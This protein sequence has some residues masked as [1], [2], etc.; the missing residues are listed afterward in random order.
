ME[1]EPATARTI[2]I[3]DPEN[4]ELVPAKDLVPAY[5][6]LTIPVQT[7]NRESR[8]YA[9]IRLINGLEATIVSDNLLDRS[10]GCIDVATGKFNDPED[11]AGTA[12]YCEHLLF[13]GSKKY[14]EENEFHEYIALNNGYFNAATGNSNTEFHFEVASDAL[15]GA[16]ERFSAFFYCPRFHKD[17]ALREIKSI[18]S[19]YSG[20][21]QDDIRRL[22]YMEF[23]L[24]HS[25][26]PLRKFGTGSEDT[27]I[28]KRSSSN[29]STRSANSTTGTLS[30]TEN[31]HISRE[32]T[33]IPSKTDPQAV[34]EEAK[35]V[36]A[37]KARE[38]L[39]KWWKRE[40]CAERMKLAIVGK[41]PLYEIIDMVVRL[42][43]P[44]K[45][46]GQYPAVVAFP[47]QPYGKEELGKIVYVKTIEKMYEIIITFPIPWQI[48]QW[49]EKPVY[50][51]AHLL[52][53]EGPHSL[54]A[55]LKN[56]GWLLRLL[57]GHAIYGHG[58]SLLKL[59]LELTKEGL[60]NY[61]EVI[62]T[63]FKFIN[64]LR[65]SQIPS[66]MHQERYWIEWLSFQHDREPQALPLVRNIVDSMKYPTRRDLLLNGPLLPWEWKPWEENPVKDMLENLDV[67]NCY[68]IV[69][70][71][72]HDHT[73][74]A[75]TWHKERWFGAEYVQK[76]FDAKFISKA[77]E[78]NDIR[79][80]AF[81]GTNP[82]ILKNIVIYGVGVN[83]PKKRPALILC[84]PNMEVWYRP[85]DQFRS[86]HAI[87][88]IA[89]QT[90]FAGATPRAK[91]LTHLI[92]DLVKDAVHEYAFYA[93]VAGLGYN[94]FGTSR[95]FEVYFMGYSEKLRDLVQAVLIGLKRLDIREDRLQVMIKRVT[96]RAFKNERLS[97]PYEICESRLQYLIQDD[98]LTTEEKLDNLKGITA[99]KLSEHVDL[100]LSRLNFVLLTNG[101][102][103]KEASRKS[104]KTSFATSSQRYIVSCAFNRFLILIPTGC[105][106]VWE[107]P[108]LNT[109]EANSSVLY[110]CHVGSESDRRTRVKCHLLSQVLK[111][112]AFDIL[113]T[114]QQLGY[115]VYTCTM[116]DIDSIGWQLVIASEYDTSYLES[117]I[118]AFLIHM[119][120]VIRSMSEEM[121][122]NH[123]R[124]LQ[125]QWTEEPKGMPDETL[126]F[127]YTI[128][129]GYYEFDGGEKDAEVLPSI[130]LQ[131]VRVMFETFFD[132]SSETRSKISIH[133]RSQ[134][135]PKVPKHPTPPNVSKMASQRFLRVLNDE[136]ISAR[137][138][139]YK[140]QCDVEPTLPEMHKYLKK[141][142]FSKLLSKNDCKVKEM[143][144]QL[145]KLVEKY[146]V[147]PALKVKHV[148]NGTKFKHGL[149][150][151][152]V[153]ILDKKFEVEY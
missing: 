112:P 140:Q 91:I 19:E 12:H 40:Y 64:L 94:L 24:A 137:E 74:K 28:G 8:K 133:A 45:S 47:Q 136:H 17:A 79:D 123:K 76:R 18:D 9:V 3:E 20:K 96:R 121:F 72:N 53:H 77:R 31:S 117:R 144:Q 30:G 135:I 145:N 46:R 81:P 114:K 124:S 67:E 68:V 100:L 43:S 151:S 49:R 13:M 62:L 103:R 83:A 39:K 128:Q 37:L 14:P 108:V 2:L 101:N 116:T 1:G 105:N 22:Q 98:C 11:M 132:P 25:S 106:Y 21:L 23:A 48:P 122:E 131:E 44:I 88:H 32:L 10:A 143:F 85:N 7:S 118:D 5:Y 60:Q 147:R 99:E 97:R 142:C 127:W 146:P 120:K 149:E 35:K 38:K 54:Y 66:W 129:G 59:T 34:R 109:K 115:T 15:K 141:T 41:E 27:L 95:G 119:R 93:R 73:L 29:S 36:A 134:S 153:E 51:L 69:A 78:D 126:R 130:P 75:E 104:P 71:R 61:R 33:R 52:G 87:V 125:K 92:M 80:L 102:L 138:D 107:L 111:E 139:E 150:L 82:F 84:A 110:Y 113:R 55:Y 42:F 4:W 86:P 152:R 16:L 57:S 58:I 26:H 65:K 70:A 63:C 90:P 6:I 56:K 89:A 148:K 50:Y